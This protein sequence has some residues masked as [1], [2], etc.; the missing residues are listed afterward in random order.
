MLLVFSQRT[1]TICPSLSFSDGIRPL[2]KAREKVHVSDILQGVPTVRSHL[3]KGDD[4]EKNWRQTVGSIVR[5]RWFGDIPKPVRLAIKNACAHLV[6]CQPSRHAIR[7]GNNVPEEVQDWLLDSR[8]R[9]VCNHESRTH[10]PSDLSRYVFAAAW[11][12]V[13]GLSLI[14]I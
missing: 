7:T 9:H 13:F 10:M 3:S 4:G 11:G 1:R 8:I 5:Q 12:T 6:R 2:E 14:H